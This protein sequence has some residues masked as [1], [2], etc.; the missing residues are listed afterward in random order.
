MTPEDGAAFRADV[1][2]GRVSVPQW[3]EMGAAPQAA[4]EQPQLTEE[5]GG[6]LSSIVDFAK[7]IPEMITGTERTTETSQRLPEWQELPELSKFWSIPTA[8]VAL[9]QMFASPKETEQIIQA[10]FPNI[11]VDHDEKG[12][13]IFTSAIDGKQYAF[14][15]GFGV[16]DIPRAAGA[17]TAGV[18]TGGAA[19]L[20]GLVGKEMATQAI[21]E[22]TQAGT[23]GQFDPADVALAGAI[24]AGLRVAGKGLGAARR[25]ATGADVPVATRVPDPEPTAPDTPI[26]AMPSADEGLYGLDQKELSGIVNKARGK[27]IGSKAAKKKLAKIFAQDPTVVDAAK[28]LGMDLPPDVLAKEYAPGALAGVTR[29]TQGSDPEIAWRK[30]VDDATQQAEDIMME[31]EALYASIGSEVAPSMADAAAKVK[32]NIEGTKAKWEADAKAIFDEKKNVVPDSSI[33]ELQNVED[34]LL[35]RLVDIGE[36]EMT[37]VEMNLLKRVEEG[38]MTMKGLLRHKTKMR[39]ATQGKGNEWSESLDNAEIKEI[40]SALR[41]DQI[42]NVSRIGGE[43]LGEKL[44][45]ANKLWAKKSELDEHLVKEFG[46]DGLG[47]LGGK[48]GSAF[49]NIDKTQNFDRLMSMVPEELRREVLM[50]GVAKASRSMSGQSAV[51]GG[52]GFSE[53]A[54]FYRKLRSDSAKTKYFKDN[55]GD[56]A[57]D[58][59]RDLFEVSKRIT[60]ARALASRGTGADLQ[61]LLENLQAENLVSSVLNSGAVS[62][63]VGAMP[64]VGKIAVAGV[65]GISNALSTGGDKAL[66]QI[67]DLITSPQFK[68]LIENLATATE[69][70]G[71]KMA[72]KFVLTNPF[73]QFLKHAKIRATDPEKWILDAMRTERN[74]SQDEE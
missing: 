19:S 72:K 57:F 12:N 74:I 33:V 70:E 30:T 26:E 23:G 36:D 35:K 67:G 5:E 10:N 71:E 28:R 66:N 29:K 17:L 16:S 4:P 55:I 58:S 27:G 40:E 8:S 39:K 3:F 64:K 43:E 25:A 34:L 18:A 32:S 60:R 69:A 42:A 52:F 11:K 49:K 21:I 37:S 22:A 59:M 46:K 45:E 41:E 13:A 51:K 47:N 68:K 14:K 7:G 1:E 73:R 24:P 48:L 9:G 2:A 6:F 53:Y 31:N 61:P 20:P 50:T 63:A 62:G 15:P 54:D 56:A 44:R 38:N 65:G